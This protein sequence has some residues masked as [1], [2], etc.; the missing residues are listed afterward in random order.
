MN[1][2]ILFSA[3]ILTLAFAAP[4]TAIA[5]ST[6]GPSTTVAA[7]A[8]ATGMLPQ[9]GVNPTPIVVNQAPSTA[10]TGGVIQLSAFGWL[11]PYVD[12]TVQAFI[13]AF[14]AWLGK[15]KYSQWLDQS[16]RD[17]LETFL[18]NRASSLIADGAV[19]LQ[20]KAVQVNN[21]MLLKAANE[22]STAIPDAMKRFG[23]TPDV[24]AQKII[25]AIPQTESGAAMIATAHAANDTPPV[26]VTD[27]PPA[28][29]NPQ[30]TP[31]S[32]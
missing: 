27:R 26:P 15:S 24:V 1:R 10:P 18:K 29:P 12:S 5:Q 6:A 2:K 11:E 14:F 8:P 20:N 19:N 13:V 28:V 3:L 32:S 31:L 4:I 22:A 30:T 17:A 25:D 7:P 16:S 9:V 21:P 23:L